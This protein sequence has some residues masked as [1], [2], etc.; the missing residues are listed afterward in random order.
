MKSSFFLFWGSF[1]RT[2]SA[3]LG[4]FIDSGSQLARLY[5]ATDSRRFQHNTASLITP[6]DRRRRPLFQHNLTQPTDTALMCLRDFAY[7]RS[8]LVEKRR[9]THGR[10]CTRTNIRTFLSLCGGELPPNP[11]LSFSLCYI[12]LHTQSLERVPTA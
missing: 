8:P 1:T 6:A 5:S 9:N 12:L 3:S 11:I 7:W 2:P 10:S 4:G